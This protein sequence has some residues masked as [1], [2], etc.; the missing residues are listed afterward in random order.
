MH[1]VGGAAWPSVSSFGTRPT[2][3]GVEPLLEAH[4]FDFEGDLYGERLALD[5]VAH[6]RHMQRFDTVEALVKRIAQDVDDT[7]AA[8]P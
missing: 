1:G 7:R 8:L 5:F 2:V 4:V 6:L 3:D